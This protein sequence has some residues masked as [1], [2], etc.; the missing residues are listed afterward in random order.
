MSSTN[1][2]SLLS[3]RWKDHL[4][5]IFPRKEQ[6]IYDAVAH[7]DALPASSQT[8]LFDA[9]AEF[10]SSKSPNKRF[11]K[12]IIL[13]FTTTILIVEIIFIILTPKPASLNDTSDVETLPPPYKFTNTSGHAGCG[14]TAE[15]ALARGCM[16][17]NLTISWETPECYHSDIVSSFFSIHDWKFYND[18]LGTPIP[19][20]T[21]ITDGHQRWNV[22]WDFHFTHC[23]YTWKMMQKAVF[24]RRPLADNILDLEH[25]RHCMEMLLEKR[26]P[27]DDIHTLVHV[28]WPKCARFEEWDKAR[29]IENLVLPD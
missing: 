18:S 3:S 20:T 10:A 19:P 22:K 25:T 15:T 23:V 21:S 8:T 11:L 12:A 7:E 16:F 5:G 26:F 13:I 29:W 27:W 1:S 4:I 14:D 28:K 24:E 9:D 17:D 2:S 6:H